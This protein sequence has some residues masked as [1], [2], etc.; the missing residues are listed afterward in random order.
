MTSQNDRFDG[1]LQ[2]LGKRGT[3]HGCGCSGKGV[4][5]A[6]SMVGMGAASARKPNPLDDCCPGCLAKSGT[7]HVRGCAV[8][9]AGY[10]PSSDVIAA[11]MLADF[12]NPLWMGIDLGAPPI[13]PDS[14]IVMASKGIEESAIVT[15]TAPDLLAKAAKHMADRAATYDKP[16]GE[17]SMGKTVEAFNAITGQNL[18]E[19][20]GWLLLQVLKSVRMFQRPGYHADS[21]EDNIAYGGL[22]GEAKAKEIA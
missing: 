5:G 18:T 8:H 15:I 17:R 14:V 7:T 2:C 22:M 16:E 11:K 4:I 10:T 12:D 9:R 3:Y 19:A 13:P 6:S 20:Q 21:A 1:C